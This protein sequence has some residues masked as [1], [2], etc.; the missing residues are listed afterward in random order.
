VEDFPGT[1]F[2][3]NLLKGFYWQQIAEDEGIALDDLPR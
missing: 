3:S 2:E 1:Y